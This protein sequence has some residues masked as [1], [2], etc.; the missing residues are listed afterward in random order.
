M[1][2]GRLFRLVLV[3][4]ALVALGIVVTTTLELT[5]AALDLIE[6]LRNEPLPVQLAIG[7]LVG[8][9]VVLTLWLV[10]LLLRP[11]RAPATAPVPV[12][13]EDAMVERID[14]AAAAGVDVSAAR[15][16][17][18]RRERSTASL[19]VAVFGEIS[20]GKSSL[21]GALLP[22]AQLAASPLGGT[23][24]KV[25]SYWWT[26]PGGTAVQ[27]LDLPGLALVGGDDQPLL[28]EARRAHVVLFVCDS[29][30]TR[31]DVV[32]IERLVAAGKP[33]IVALNKADRYEAEEIRQI[34]A[35]I[36]ERVLGLESDLP[37]TVIPAIAG[38]HAR[39]VERGA[40]GTERATTRERQ[41]D[42]D[43]L[44][45]ALNHLVSNHAPS[46]VHR[47]DQ[48]LFQLAGDKLRE[49]E[50]AFRRHRGEEIVR[51]HT[52]KAVIGALA[53]VSPGTDIVIQGYLGSSLV[54][55]LCK[56]N[57]VAVSD[58]DIDQFLDLSQSRVGR[59][60]PLAL[61]IAGNGLKAF[62]GIGTVTGGA[63][64]AIAYGLIFDA[65]G[66]GLLVSLAER[67]EFV[68]A[69]AAD[70]FG[71]ELSMRLEERVAR[72]ARIAV[73]QIGNDKS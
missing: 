60:L 51:S 34:L 26:S 20:A 59:A 38:G 33:M 68:T 40:D 15:G 48:A 25:D 62:P 21:I 43:Q 12:L 5:Q 35:R 14:Q 30:L 64:H 69:N 7:A 49:A 58:V 9:A 8:A 2:A 6:R 67:G 31:A 55:E 63:V 65:L 46:L 10:W 16:E 22:G 50:L 54:R 19:D 45:A 17:L 73:A 42:I 44:V 29:D 3:L 13:D 23:T 52:R 18:A 66:R 39:V 56:L 28:D 1:S 32:T 41:T 57:G 27:L 71:A 37:V 24:T 36:H 61:A 53:A 70:R 4:V 47:R 11:S 72:I